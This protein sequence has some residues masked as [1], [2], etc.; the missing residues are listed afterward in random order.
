MLKKCAL[1]IRGCIRMRTMIIVLIL[2]VTVYVFNN[3]YE[4][5]SN[6][7][8]VQNSRK[9]GALF[10]LEGIWGKM[11]RIQQISDGRSQRAM[12][13]FENAKTVNE[14][15]GLFSVDIPNSWKI[16]SE[17]G[18]NGKQLAKII[19]ESPNF[20]QRTEGGNIFYDNGAQLTI[21]V[22]QGEESR[23]KLP[24][25]GYGSLLIKKAS[26][27]MSEQKANYYV[28]NEINVKDGEIINAH[29]LHNGNTY[30]FRLVDNPRIFTGGEYSFQ[31]ILYSLKFKK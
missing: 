5:I 19:V 23:A 1:F 27:D 31:E 11:K 6:L 28:I 3:K 8:V 22:V 24:D 26:V 21:Q 12:E 16:I 25:G 20:S 13:L 10:Y 2:L 7:S 18:V 29:I 4:E 14:K 9:N 17:E 30:N 15:S